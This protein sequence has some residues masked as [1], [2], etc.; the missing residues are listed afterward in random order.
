SFIDIGGGLPSRNRLKNTYLPA[1]IATPPVEEYAEAVTNALLDSLNPNH[2]PQLILE[3]G[4]A[5]IDEAGTLI[6]SVHASKRLPDGRR[7]YVLDAGVNLLFTS[8]W[9]RFNIE[10]DRPVT[11]MPEPSILYGPLCMNIDV[12]DEGLS[13]PPLVRGTR[14]LLSPVGAYSVT[15]WM[16]FIHYRPR[17]VMIRQNGQV[18]VIREHEDLQTLIGPERLPEEDNPEVNLSIVA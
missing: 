2:F 15:Q 10:F 16:Q 8:F 12:V 17:V 13:L 18:D 11:G 14:M 6:T 9:Y 5:M 3:S 4:R 7:A 1:D